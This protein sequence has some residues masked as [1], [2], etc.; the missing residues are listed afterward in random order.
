MYIV[1]FFNF[2]K[3]TNGKKKMNFDLVN[4]YE[5]SIMFRNYNK[6]KYNLSKPSTHMG[7]ASYLTKRP[8]KPDDDLIMGVLLAGLGTCTGWSLWSEKKNL[9]SQ[10]MYD[11]MV[12]STI[13][14][15]VSITGSVAYII[16]YVRR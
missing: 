14:S 13:L 6:F 2:F 8:R 11:N 3:F 4:T 9:K 10:Y 1:Y 5:L 15:G 12:L 16:K 7:Y